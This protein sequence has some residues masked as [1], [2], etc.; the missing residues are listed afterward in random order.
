MA[1][2]TTGLTAEEAQAAVG[3]GVN[4]NQVCRAYNSREGTVRV[5]YDLPTGDEVKRDVSMPREEA[6]AEP[7]KAA[8]KASKD[9]EVAEGNEA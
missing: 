7:E 3:E 1:D 2:K 6:P 5:L 4:I 8:K 9:N